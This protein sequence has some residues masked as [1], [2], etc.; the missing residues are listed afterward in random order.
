M[1]HLSQVHCEDCTSLTCSICSVLVPRCLR[2]GGSWLSSLL[3]SSSEDEITCTC[4]HGGLLRWSARTK[5]VTSRIASRRR[6]S[7]KGI[8]SLRVDNRKRL[9][10]LTL[11]NPSRATAR[12]QRWYEKRSQQSQSCK[13][14]QDNHDRWQTPSDNMSLLDVV[15]NCA[16]TCRCLGRRVR[17]D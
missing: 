7:D 3:D 15:R 11:T 10:D 4:E 17:C 14:E 16:F 9:V 5:P 12:K 13:D 6:A 2:V 8:Y 1:V